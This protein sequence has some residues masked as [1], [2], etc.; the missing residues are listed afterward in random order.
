MSAARIRLG[1]VGTGWVAGQHVAGAQ[2]V[3]AGDVEIVAA[4]DPRRAVL[5]EFCD[6]HGIPHRFETADGMMASGTV[7]AV[8]LLTPPSVRWEVIAPALERGLHVLVE[9]PFAQSGPDA[10]RFTEAAE[11]AGVVMAVS[12]N[13][14]WFPEYSWLASRVQRADTGRTD[15]LEAR[16]FQNR[17]QAPGVWRSEEA[18]LEMAIFSVHLIDRLQWLAP[19]VP[20]SVRALTR[21]RRGSAISGEQ[22]SSLLVE[23]ADGIVG[24]VTSSWTSRALPS[25]T[26]RIDTDTGSAVVERSLPMSGTARGIAAFGGEEEHIDF[27]ET[28]DGEHAAVSYGSSA[29]EFA[30]AIQEQREPAHSARNNLRTMGIMEAAYRSA[31]RGGAP[32]TL[33]EVLYGHPADG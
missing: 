33:E 14:R 23:F 5:D 13:F 28:A 3:A 32:V 30:R 4:C 31:S 15:F 6:R 1:L 22:F 24:S 17:P 10:V 9:K 12:Q 29:V 27:A 11:A 8:V 19:S 18:K 2:G 7:D 25:N 21:R 26:F 16:T 20:T